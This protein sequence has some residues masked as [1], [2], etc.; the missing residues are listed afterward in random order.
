MIDHPS[1]REGIKLELDHG[2]DGTC[3]NAQVPPNYQVQRPHADLSARGRAATSRAGGSAARGRA[4]YG[5]T[6]RCNAELGGAASLREWYSKTIATTPS[7]SA[8]LKIPV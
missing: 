8:T 7:I 4:L 2:S 6:V 5:G 3:R 1:I